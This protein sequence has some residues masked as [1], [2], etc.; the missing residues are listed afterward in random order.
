[1]LRDQNRESVVQEG[2]GS[3][4][5]SELLEIKFAILTFAKMWK[6]SAI[7]IQ[8]ANRTALSHLLKMRGKKNPD[9]MNISK[10][11]WEFYF[12]RGSRL[13]PNIYQEISIARQIGNI[14]TRKIPQNG[15]CAI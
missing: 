7:H 11:I 8:V 12:G 5:Q 2:T 13:L 9:L 1:M 14:G 6:M 4:Y 3:T 15:N 10:E